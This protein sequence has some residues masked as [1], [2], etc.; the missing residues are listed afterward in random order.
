MVKYRRNI[1]EYSKVDTMMRRF[2]LAISTLY[3]A[4]PTAHFFIF[5]HDSTVK[6]ESYGLGA[7]LNAGALF[8]DIK[9]RTFDPHFLSLL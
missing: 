7:Y 2:F 4:A 8:R 3:T 9:S 1:I 5:M 6:T